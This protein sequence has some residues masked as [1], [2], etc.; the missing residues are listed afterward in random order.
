MSQSSTCSF[1]GAVNSWKHSLIECNMANNIWALSNDL[2]VENMSACGETHARNWLFHLLETL[3]HDQFT[4]LSV[5]LWAIWT[6]RRKAIHKDIFQ[7]PLTTHGFI[8]S[9]IGE[10]QSLAKPSARPSVNGG[11]IRITQRWIPPSIPI[12]KAKVDAAV[13]KTRSGSGNVSR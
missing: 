6:S 8:N 1:C 5:T 11:N 3:P 10:L 12:P 2:M 13:S 7:S 4:R 9:F